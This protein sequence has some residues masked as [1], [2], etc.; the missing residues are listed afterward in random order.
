MALWRQHRERGE[1]AAAWSWGVPWMDQ[2][3]GQLGPGD[4]LV[5]GARTNVG[6]SMLTLG[7]LAGAGYAKTCYVSCEDPPWRVGRR[8]EALGAG[9]RI[10]CA[11]P[12]RRES[13]A[14]ER[15]LQEAAGAGCVLVGVDY[16]QCLAYSGGVACFNEVGAAA[17]VVDDLKHAAGRAGVALLAVSQ[18]RRPPPLSEGG[19][20]PFP[21]LWELKETS[22]IEDAAEVVLLLGPTRDRRG[23]VVELA[24]CK[25]GEVGARARLRRDPRNGVLS[26]DDGGTEGGGD[27][28]ERDAGF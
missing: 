10:L 27:D 3:V 21:K 18:I 17:R 16:L 15:C 5:V 4:M 24:K 14:V 20:P 28:G 1:R 13:G 6:K 8:L 2:H 25:D 26:W 12:E 19:L 23:V 22:R 7:L 11:W 9:L